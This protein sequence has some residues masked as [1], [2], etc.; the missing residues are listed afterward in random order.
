MIS[1]SI[2]ETKLGTLKRTEK[3]TTDPIKPS[4]LLFSLEP[5][6]IFATLYQSFA[7]E[8]LEKGPVLGAY[9][10]GITLPVRTRS[11]GCDDTG[12][13][14]LVVFEYA[15]MRHQPSSCVSI[16]PRIERSA[17]KRRTKDSFE[18]ASF[19][20]ISINIPILQLTP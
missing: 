16:H 10:S 20:H 12:L 11:F 4:E 14:K 2:S 13:N 7:K 15:I 19:D 18:L 6:Y 1:D 5:H 8:V 3:S 17:R 9:A